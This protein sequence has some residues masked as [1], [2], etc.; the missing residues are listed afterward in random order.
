MNKKT[1]YSFSRD[2]GAQPTGWERKE[3]I[4]AAWLLLP[5]HQPALYLGMDPTGA[6]EL[7]SQKPQCSAKP[8]QVAKSLI[9]SQVKHL[10]ALFEF[11]FFS[12][13]LHC[14]S[15]QELSDLLHRGLNASVSHT[16]SPL[17]A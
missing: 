1:T 16:N 15:G 2:T 17:C 12:C 14:V 13:C 10:G 8:T 7:I 6:W 9:E 4:A 5:E 11:F 3:E